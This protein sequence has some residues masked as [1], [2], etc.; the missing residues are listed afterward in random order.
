MTS[1]ATSLAVAL[2]RLVPYWSS[3]MKVMFDQ[4]RVRTEEIKPA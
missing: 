3:E 2:E 1:L 4:Y